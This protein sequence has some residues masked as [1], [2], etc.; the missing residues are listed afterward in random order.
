MSKKNKHTDVRTFRLPKGLIALLGAEALRRKETKQKGERIP[1]I[2]SIAVEILFGALMQ[3]DQKGK[4]PIIE[5]AEQY[6]EAKQAAIL[7][8]AEVEGVLG[9]GW[10]KNVDVGGVPADYLHRGRKI[11]VETK[12]APTRGRLE[13]ALGQALILKLKTRAR[14]VV[15]IPWWSRDA[16]GMV[17][18][19][20]RAEVELVPFDKLRGIIG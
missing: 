17:A 5:R 11:L 20:R 10:E 3:Q 4:M 7:F 14:V 8:E 16:E 13:L 12:S 1:T 19:Y 15:V 6:L 2:N 18:E 9:T